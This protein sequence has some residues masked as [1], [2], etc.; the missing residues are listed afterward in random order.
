MPRA[1]IVPG[2]RYHVYNRGHNKQTLFFDK[3]DYVRMLFYLLFLQAPLPTYNASRMVASYLKNGYFNSSEMFTKEILKN[4]MVQLESFTLMPN[5]IH[6]AVLELKEY[7]IASYMQKVEIAYTKYFNIRYKRFGYLF[8]GPFQSIHIK[9]NRQLLHLS[10]YIHRN[11]VEVKTWR[12]RE[13]IYPWS[14][15]QD[16][17]HKNRWDELLKTDTVVSQFD[18]ALEYREFVRTSGTKEYPPQ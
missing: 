8:Q 9:T 4:R 5:H 6:I 3:Q 12:G 7:G 11:I 18:D 1:I 2:E 16:Y 13:N 14:S 17:D 15:Y 10:A